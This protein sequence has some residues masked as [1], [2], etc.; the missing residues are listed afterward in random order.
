MSYRKNTS[1]FLKTPTAT[2][3]IRLLSEGLPYREVCEITG[4]RLGTLKERN[5]MLY[6]VNIYTA[7]RDRLLREGIP[8]RLSVVDEFGNYFAGLFDGEG[9]FVCWYRRRKTVS[10][11]MPEYRLGV[12]IQL[13]QDDADVLRFVHKNLGGRICMSVRNKGKTNPACYWRVE[14]SEDLVEVIIPLFD[15]FHLRSKKSRE[16]VIWRDLA[17]HRY[18]MTI[19]GNAR[20][21]TPEWFE[22]KFTKAILE[23]DKIRRYLIEETISKTA[24]FSLAYQHLGI[25]DRF[26]GGGILSRITDCPPSESFKHQTGISTTQNESLSP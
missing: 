11:M 9:T 23:I 17:L 2:T 8:N 1:D 13:R 25:D 6:H 12:Q 19:A 14:K 21:S 20:G 22:G 24:D 10:G 3:E 5:R 16:Y 26:K 15:K 4:V 18:W 7:F